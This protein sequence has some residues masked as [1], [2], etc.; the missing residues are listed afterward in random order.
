[1]GTLPGAR[2]NKHNGTGPIVTSDGLI[3]TLDKPNGRYWVENGDNVV[4]L[5]LHWSADRSSVTVK[6]VWRSNLG[7]RGSKTRRIGSQPAWTD[8]RVYGRSGLVLDLTNGQVITERG[9]MRWGAGDYGCVLVGNALVVPNRFKGTYHFF[10][11]D[12]AGNEELGV[13]RLPLGDNGVDV[14]GYPWQWTGG[15]IPWAAHNRLYIRTFDALWCIG[16]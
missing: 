10:A 7:N 6:E 16:K 11:A 13:G 1:V 2:G 3:V 12:A 9:L 15:A 5:R 8:R 14:M 4:G